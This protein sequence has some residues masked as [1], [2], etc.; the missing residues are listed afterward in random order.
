MSD[1]LAI[2]VLEPHHHDLRI[3]HQLELPFHEAP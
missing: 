1:T 3:D 2:R